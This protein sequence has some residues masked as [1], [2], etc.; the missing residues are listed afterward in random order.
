MIKLFE[1]DEHQNLMFDDLGSGAMVQSNQHIIVS[2]NEVM[3]LDPGGHKVY[4]SLFS[5]ISHLVPPDGLKYIF[6]SHQDPDRKS[7]R[8]NSSHTDISRMPS[9]A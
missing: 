8:L 1:S 4:M 3:I 6:F 2:G 9:S 5:E 7:T